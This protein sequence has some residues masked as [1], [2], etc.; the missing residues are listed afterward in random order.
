MDVIY[1]GQSVDTT[2]FHRTKE[3]QAQVDAAKQQAADAE[4]TIN[5]LNNATDT[6]AALTAANNAGTPL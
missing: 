5:Q 1:A 4:N 6:Q 2:Q 3:E